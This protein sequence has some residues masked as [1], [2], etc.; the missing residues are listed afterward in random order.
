MKE[1]SSLRVTIDTSERD[2]SIMSVAGEIDMVSAPELADHLDQV[3]GRGV[4]VVAD[5]SAVS[6]IDSSGL[7]ELH[8]A[9]DVGRVVL[10]VEPAATIARVVALSGF[11]EDVQ[12]FEDVT[13]ARCWIA[14]AG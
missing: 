1:S 9:S 10:V 6:F 5:L 7:R 3:I 13:S 12:V 14:G 4:P 11:G 8:R 2:L